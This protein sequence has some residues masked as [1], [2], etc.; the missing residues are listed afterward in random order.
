MVASSAANKDSFEVTTP[1]EQEIRM[2]RLFDAPRHLVFEAMTRPE[3]VKRWW[4]CLGE[5]YSVPV[6]EIDLRLGGKW[7]FVNRHPGGEAA[8]HGEYREITPPSRVVFTEIFEDYPDVVSVVTS[9]L[10]EEGP[11][12]RLTVTVRYPSMEVRDA[13]IATGMSTGAGIS[14]DRLEDL[15]G[16]LR[17]RQDGRAGAAQ[18]ARASAPR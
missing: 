12:T 1:S 14:Y 2:T 7:R 9:D 17:A 18:A 8:F 5:G 3:H 13:V 15:V 11:K 16:E 4:G 10:A 6:C